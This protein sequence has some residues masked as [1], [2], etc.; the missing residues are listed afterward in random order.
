MAVELKGGLESAGLDPGAPPMSRMHV[1]PTEK[2]WA[3]YKKRGGKHYTDPKSLAE[4]L[5]LRVVELQRTG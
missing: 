1:L 2:A 3:E 5:V 4:A